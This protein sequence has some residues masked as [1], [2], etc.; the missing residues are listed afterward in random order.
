MIKALFAVDQN[1]GMGYN[2][3]LPW[4]HNTTD[5]SHFQ[6]MTDGHVVVMGKNSWNDKKMPKPLKGRTVY[7]ASNSRVQYA[8][9]ISGD[10]VLEL[11][12]IEKQHPD[13]IIWVCGG[14]SIL[15]ACLKVTDE[16]VITHFK[17]AYKYDT[18]IDVDS[19]LRGFTPV[20]ATVSS[21]FKSTIVR[22]TPLFKRNI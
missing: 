6:K 2:G 8:S 9:R 19:Y 12:K 22:Y 3:S 15:K 5:M 18:S 20:G 10:L 7:I 11:L 21:D 14:P 1:G 4:K 13:Q 17:D 16:I